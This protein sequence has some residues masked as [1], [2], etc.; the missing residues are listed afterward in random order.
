MNKKTFLNCTVGV[1]AVCL[2][3]VTAQ[4]IPFTI[5]L[6]P[7]PLQKALPGAA[8]AGELISQQAQATVRLTVEDW[9]RKHWVVSGPTPWREVEQLEANI[10]KSMYAQFMVSNQLK[11]KMLH[12]YE[13]PDGDGTRFSR[14][15]GFRDVAV[16]GQKG[17]RI[18]R[19]LL[20]QHFDGVE[21]FHVLNTVLGAIVKENSISYG[22]AFAKIVTDTYA[23]MAR[24]QI[25]EWNLDQAIAAPLREFASEKGLSTE[26]APVF[27]PQERAE[28]MPEWEALSWAISF[29]EFQVQK[30]EGAFPTLGL[31]P[32]LDVMIMGLWNKILERELDL[33]TL[34][35]LTDD[36]LYTAG[37]NDIER[38]L[39]ASI[40]FFRAHERWPGVRLF[41]KRKMEAQE[42]MERMRADELTA[43]EIEEVELGQ[44]LL[45]LLEGLP[46]SYMDKLPQSVQNTILEISEDIG[47]EYMMQLGGYYP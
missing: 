3:A 7:K 46:G 37:M 9:L 41:A 42:F 28:E 20:A 5:K 21:S 14:G 25:Q 38:V 39:E 27:F 19:E 44:K 6:M 33:P 16:S 11:Q 1:L 22:S 30:N 35:L 34:Y 47:N 18:K 10:R 43:E 2:V 12:I 29:T 31:D 4:A 24:G 23:A 13:F 45:L 8:K 40:C 17:P 26:D 32:D 15:I 36:Y